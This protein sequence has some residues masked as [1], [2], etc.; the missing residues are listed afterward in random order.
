M[1]A[2][3]AADT[4][5]KNLLDLAEAPRGANELD[6]AAVALLDKFPSLEIVVVF[7]A[8]VMLVVRYMSDFTNPATACDIAVSRSVTGDGA[9]RTPPGGSP[10]T[11]EL[12]I[13][14]LRHLDYRR[15]IDVATGVQATTATSK[16]ILAAAAV[17]LLA[18]LARGLQVP[19][20]VVWAFGA[21]ELCATHREAQLVGGVAELKQILQYEFVRITPPKVQPTGG[22]YTHT[23]MW[24][25][26]ACGHTHRPDL[27]HAECADRLRSGCALS[28]APVRRN[29]TRA[30]SRTLTVGCR[31]TSWPTARGR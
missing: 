13:L 22:M 16:G 30:W 10:K 4:E 6:Q 2:C 18:G 15:L 12:L 24:M 21:M 3:G 8:P 14:P 20:A 11:R 28:C 17:G 5:A 27:L 1:A 9:S 7:Q 25:G 23:R 26:V 29:W 31:N 19:Q